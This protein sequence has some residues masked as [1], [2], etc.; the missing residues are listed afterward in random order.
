MLL[1]SRTSVNKEEG[2]QIALAK[3]ENIRTRKPQ[4]HECGCFKNREMSYIPIPR[5]PVLPSYPLP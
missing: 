1:T 2:Y 3:I 5:I 4:L